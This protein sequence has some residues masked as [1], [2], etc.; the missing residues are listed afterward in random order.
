VKHAIRSDDRQVES[1]NAWN[2]IDPSGERDLNSVE[3]IVLVIGGI[4]ELYVEFLIELNGGAGIR[5]RSKITGSSATRYN[6]R[7]SSAGQRIGRL[8]SGC[9]FLFCHAAVDHS[10]DEQEDE[11]RSVR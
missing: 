6:A 3:V 4:D 5:F 2:R 7:R 9:N 8:D 1:S 11:D 10:D